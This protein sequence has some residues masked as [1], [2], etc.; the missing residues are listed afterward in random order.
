MRWHTL[1]IGDGPISS[2][3]RNRNHS[4]RCRGWRRRAATVIGEQHRYKNH[5]VRSLPHYYLSYSRCGSD[6]TKVYDATKFAK[7]GVRRDLRVCQA[8]RSVSCCQARGRRD[9]KFAKRREVSLPSA[10]QTESLPRRP[11]WASTAL[12]RHHDECKS[13]IAGMRF[14]F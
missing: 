14:A 10:P 1:T 4:V 5:H 3:E 13:K 11:A 8:Q 9:V 6:T 7:R 2:I 12:H